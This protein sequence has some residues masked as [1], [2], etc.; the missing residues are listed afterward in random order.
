MTR[1]IPASPRSEVSDPNKAGPNNAGTP[2]MP[3][4]SQTIISWPVSWWSTIK[5]FRNILVMCGWSQRITTIASK[6]PSRR[7]VPTPIFREDAMFQRR[8]HVSEKTPCFREDAMPLC[9]AELRVVSA[10]RRIRICPMPPDQRRLAGGTLPREQ[11]QEATAMN[12]PVL[13][14]S[15]RRSAGEL[16]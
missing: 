13:A 5:E 16:G 10:A 12:G 1:R 2:C 15:T 4:Y 14:F 3:P 6:G 7:S 8:R 11:T 9:Q